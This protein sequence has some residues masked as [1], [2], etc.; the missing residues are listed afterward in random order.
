M[1]FEVLDVIYKKIF[2]TTVE[3][4]KKVGAADIIGRIMEGLKD[5]S[6]L[7]RRMVI[8]TL[9]KVVA[10]L[11]ASDIDSCLDELLV[12]GVLYAIFHEQTIDDANVILNSFGAVVKSLG[13]RSLM[14]A[15]HVI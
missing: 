6:E 4:A 8:E 15:Y 11:G 10:K 7:Y 5:E 14:L 3:L 1:D 9:G 13:P 12:Y 2:E